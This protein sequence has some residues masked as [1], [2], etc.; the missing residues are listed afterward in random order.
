MRFGLGIALG[1]FGWV[2]ACTA[3]PT[4][5]APEE[6]FTLATSPTVAAP[7]VLPAAAP[8]EAPWG[9]AP[10]IGRL[11]SETHHYSN[12]CVDHRQVDILALARGEMRVP[13]IIGW[14]QASPRYR[15]E[16]HF[17]SRKDE[18]SGYARRSE[19]VLVS[20]AVVAYAYEGYGGAPAYGIEAT[21]VTPASCP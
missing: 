4:E 16:P 17:L 14:R 15:G 21:Q 3:P 10:W 20:G 5:P 9:P 6:T 13:I 19:C 8:I 12:G 11:T 7:P 18:L 1:A 2:T